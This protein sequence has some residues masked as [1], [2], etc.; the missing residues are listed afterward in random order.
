MRLETKQFYSFPV[1]ETIETSIG[2]S[3]GGISLFAAETCP[4]TWVIYSKGES[5]QVKLT[6]A[7]FV[8]KCFCPETNTEEEAV[9]VFLHDRA[10]FGVFVHVWIESPRY[11]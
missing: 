3:Q 10:C 5:N 2:H 8:T 6:L 7:V 11:K 9:C 1:A 4:F